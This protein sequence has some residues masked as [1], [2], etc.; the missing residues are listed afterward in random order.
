MA[1]RR[2]L[3]EGPRSRG[4]DGGGVCVGPCVI[5]TC[6]SRSGVAPTATRQ[7]LLRPARDTSS[8]A[9]TVLSIRSSASSLSSTILARNAHSRHYVMGS[10]CPGPGRV[11]EVSLEQAEELVRIDRLLH[12]GVHARTLDVLRREPLVEAGVQDDRQIGA[13]THQFVRE[14]YASHA[15]HHLI[16]NDHVEALGIA[17]D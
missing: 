17:R 9:S 12:H 3:E 7:A 8:A 4:S 15:R 16:G 1:A 14:L 13:N 11:W 10:L 6:S 5:A 2:S